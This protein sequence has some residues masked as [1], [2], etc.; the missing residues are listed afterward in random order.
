MKK[1]ATNLWLLGLAI[2]VAI[3]LK[4][5]YSKEE[6]LLVKIDEKESLPAVPPSLPEPPLPPEGSEE[7]PRPGIAYGVDYN[8]DRSVTGT[9]RSSCSVQNQ[10]ASVSDPDRSIAAMDDGFRGRGSRYWPYS[11]CYRYWW[12]GRYWCNWSNYY[13]NIWW[14]KK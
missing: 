12:N 14:G 7:Q 1:T 11:C 6:Y 8:P 5:V 3:Q 10:C 2:I 13:C 4:S 9:S